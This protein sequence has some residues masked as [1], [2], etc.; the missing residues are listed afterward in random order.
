MGTTVVVAV[1][2]FFVVA[3]VA[4][5]LIRD[6]GDGEETTQAD[7]H[8]GA[9]GKNDASSWTSYSIGP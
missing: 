1:V 4:W 2:A 3:A 5:P 7:E 6:P 8:R 9:I